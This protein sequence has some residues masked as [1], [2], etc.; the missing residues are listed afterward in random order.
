M[1]MYSSYGSITF[2]HLTAVFVGLITL[3]LI[4]VLYS[5]LLGGVFAKAG[6]PRWKAWVPLYNSWTFFKL[7]GLRGAWALLILGAFIPV[8]GT[9][10]KVLFAVCAI[11]ASYRLGKAFGKV[12][13]GWPL[14]YAL[15]GPIWCAIIS[16]GSS[17]YEPEKKPTLLF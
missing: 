1:V 8:V 17:K 2:A 15:L 6:V 14:L 3:F 4:Y 10:F 13:L 11:V 12:N 5:V 9:V 16:F 7:G